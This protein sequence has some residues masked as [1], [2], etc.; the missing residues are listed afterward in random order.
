MNRYVKEGEKD[1]IRE[2]RC[3]PNHN[4]IPRQ[5]WE[6]RNEESTE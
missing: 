2:K 3:Y 4:R 6:K 5:W 1:T